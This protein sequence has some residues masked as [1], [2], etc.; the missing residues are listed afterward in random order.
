MIALS[1]LPT[2]RMSTTTQMPQ[3]RLNPAHP[4]RPM[5]KTSLSQ[6]P[7]L[8]CCMTTN[9]PHSRLNLA[10]PYGAEGPSGCVK[11]CD[12][13]TTGADRRRSVAPCKPSANGQ[14]LDSPTEKRPG[15]RLDRMEG[16]I[17]SS[18]VQSP[19]WHEGVK[20]TIRRS[21]LA[22]GPRSVLKH[23][24]GDCTTAGRNYL[25]VLLKR[26]CSRREGDTNAQRPAEELN[27]EQGCNE[28][29]NPRHS[30]R[31]P[32]HTLCGGSIITARKQRFATTRRLSSMPSP[33]C[34]AISML[35]AR[36]HRPQRTGPSAQQEL[37]RRGAKETPQVY[38]EHFS[39]DRGAGPD[40]ARPWTLNCIL[41][42][43]RMSASESAMAGKQ[44]GG[45]LDANQRIH[46][47]H[48]R[49]KPSSSYGAP[50]QAVN[51]PKSSALTACRG[52][53][54]DG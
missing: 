1:R 20:P 51:V 8:R 33:C 10:L 25:P 30:P 7:T 40:I 24:V 28:N 35:R 41:C 46:L 4:S 49:E 32:S 45:L 27:R 34:A 54:H 36:M 5:T 31:P 14:P 19:V 9:M 11:T 26:R 18:Q 23:N 39:S 6:A 38:R 48:S 50:S 13:P 12:D 43:F 47:R 22:T 44:L 21:R 17:P 2:V 15:H 37:L 53:L 16:R 29:E 52:R 3:L 42:G